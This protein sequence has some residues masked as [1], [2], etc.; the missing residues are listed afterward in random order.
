M[1]YIH[2]GT[3]IKQQLYRSEERVF[4]SVYDQ[5]PGEV[6]FHLY[7]CLE[8]LSIRVVAATG[9]SIMTFHKIFRIPEDPRR[10]DQSAMCAIN[11]HLLD[12]RV[13]L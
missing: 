2:P 7:T 13:S 8:Y 11:R 6:K 10:A 3:M 9:G 4:R 12:D 5:P 1:L